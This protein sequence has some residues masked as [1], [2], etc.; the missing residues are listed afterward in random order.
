MGPKWASY[1][2]RTTACTA[3]LLKSKLIPKG[4]ASRKPKIDL[5]TTVNYED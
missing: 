2:I 1:K 3:V 4:S 5:V